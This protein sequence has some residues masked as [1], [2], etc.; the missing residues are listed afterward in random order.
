MTFAAL[1]ATSWALSGF[2]GAQP[3]ILVDPSLSVYAEAR[4]QCVAVSSRLYADALGTAQERVDAAAALLHEYAH[5]RQSVTL[6]PWQREGG[7]EAFSA[8]HDASL[9]KRFGQ[10]PQ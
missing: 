6:E 1:I 8:D 5:T 10:L 2:N 9:L 7:A 3:A 4:P